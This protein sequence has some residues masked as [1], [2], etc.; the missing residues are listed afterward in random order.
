LPGVQRVVENLSVHEKYAEDFADCLDRAFY[1]IDKKSDL[2]DLKNWE[3]VAMALAGSLDVVKR[4]Q[5]LAERV[6][7]LFLLRSQAGGS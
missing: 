1:A 2:G 6:R 4:R 5:D 7:T 3:V